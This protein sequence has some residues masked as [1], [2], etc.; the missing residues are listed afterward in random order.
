MRHGPLI[1]AFSFSAVAFSWMLR[2]PAG[3]PSPLSAVVAFCSCLIFFLQLR[4]ADE[5]KDDEEDARYRPYRPVPRGLVTLRELGGLFA[6]AGVLQLGL[7]LWLDARLLVLLL[8][9]WTYLALMSKEFF[10]GEWLRG[11]HLLYMVSHMAI[12]PLV[13]LYA[14]STDWLVFQGHPPSGLFWFLLASLFNG[15]VIEIGRKIRSPHDEEEG[16]AT[17]SVVWGRR[18]A[19]GMWWLVLGLS[20]ACALLAAGRIGFGLPLAIA[21]GTTFAAAVLIGLRF[22][23]H[24]PPGA[25]TWIENWSGV[26]T[27]VLYLGLGPAPLLWRALG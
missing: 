11:K 4:I 7:A 3:W 19:L 24:Q 17:Y 8:V 25:G 10:V 9:T 23:R 22:L 5:F 13:D 15:M 27:L 16:V 21:L 2:S 6:L 1:L 26:W 18:R 12:M 20:L 14:T